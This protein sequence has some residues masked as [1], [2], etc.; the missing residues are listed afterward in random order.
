MLRELCNVEQGKSE[1]SVG[2]SLL[3]EDNLAVP[4]SNTLFDS[5]FHEEDDTVSDLN[6]VSK[7]PASLVSLSADEEDAGNSSNDE[8]EYMLTTAL[9]TLSNLFCWQV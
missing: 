4:S 9:G 6:Y 8:A 3:C 7:A 2:D 1:A 5:S